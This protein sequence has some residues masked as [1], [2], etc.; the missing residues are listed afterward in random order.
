LG[1]AA[2]GAECFDKIRTGFCRCKLHSVASL[3]RIL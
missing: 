2:G 3:T 1:F